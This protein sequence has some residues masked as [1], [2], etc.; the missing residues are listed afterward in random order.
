VTWPT[1]LRWPGLAA[2]LLEL[3]RLCGHRR[4]SADALEALQVRKLRALLEHA[5]DRVPYYR[6]LLG[7]AGIEPACVTSLDDLHRIPITTKAALRAAGLAAT[8]AR[9]VEAARCVRYP[10]SGSTGEPLVVHV[11]RRENTL[12]HLVQFRSLLGV[13]LRPRDRLALLGAYR[14]VPTRVHHRLG[15]FR[16]QLIPASLPI[17][18]QIARLERFQPTVLWAYPTVLRALLERI[19]YRRAS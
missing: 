3:R 8:L 7:A 4:Q 11:S 14:A 1:A 9:G 6:R 17:E 13:G 16:R 12:R 18:E 2:E 19:G 10:T 15:L 5:A